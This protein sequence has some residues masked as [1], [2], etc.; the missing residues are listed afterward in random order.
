MLAKAA[1]LRLGGS[2]ISFTLTA[3]LRSIRGLRG[4]SAVSPAYRWA[5][6]SS[7]A[8]RLY[9]SGA[10]GSLVFYYRPRTR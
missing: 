2:S 10:Y 6:E 5:S 9:M 3:R 4:S 8:R 1:P 7:R